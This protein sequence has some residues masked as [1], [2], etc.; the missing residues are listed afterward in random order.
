MRIAVNALLAGF[1][2]ALLAFQIETAWADRYMQTAIR[3][4]L[5]YTAAA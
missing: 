5:P 1:I 4:A 2:V 3:E